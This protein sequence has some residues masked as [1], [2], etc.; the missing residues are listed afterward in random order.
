MTLQPAVDAGVMP[1]IIAAAWMHYQRSQ[2]A[3]AAPLV[4]QALSGGPVLPALWGLGSFLSDPDFKQ[5]GVNVIRGLAD[6]GVP[7]TPSVN[8]R[9]CGPRGTSTT[10]VTLFEIAATPHIRTLRDDL[11]TLLSDS[12][13][14]TTEI[15]NAAAVVSASRE[16][17]IGAIPSQRNGHSRR[18]R[19]SREARCRHNKSCAWRCTAD[20]I[21]KAYAARAQN[22]LRGAAWWTGAAI[23]TGILAAGWAVFVA[24]HALAKAATWARRKPSARCLCRYRFS[25]SLATSRA[26]PPATEGWGT[27]GATLSFRFGRP[28]RSSPISIRT[29]AT[30]CSRHSQFASSRAKDRIRSTEARVQKASMSARSS[31]AS[32][33]SLLRVEPRQHRRRRR[34]RQ[35]ARLALSSVKGRGSPAHQDCLGVR[36]DQSRLRDERRP[37]RHAPLFPEDGTSTN[38]GAGFS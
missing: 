17:A 38:L 12:R 7:L 23:L 9:R 35:L 32:S 18:A 25:S 34:L 26:S 5:L 36:G 1:A 21:A 13:E 22:A 8:G 14:S 19:T 4:E 10:R 15:Q 30:G 31:A 16:E 2:H 11:I 28:S 3:Q 27:T 29:R 6:F 33:M 37:R 20:H 24:V